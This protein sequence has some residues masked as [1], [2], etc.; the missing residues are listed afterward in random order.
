[1][2]TP[3]CDRIG[4]GSED[5][6]SKELDEHI[7]AACEMIKNEYG[8][9]EASNQAIF[10]MKQTIKTNDITA[11]RA[12]F[13]YSMF[14][15]EPVALYFKKHEQSSRLAQDLRQRVLPFIV[16]LF[17]KNSCQSPDG[18]V[19]LSMVLA[20]MWQGETLGNFPPPEKSV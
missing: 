5:H 19:L 8:D 18:F 4:E 13:L 7:I 20:E 3:L 14:A 16:P 11:K 6:V 15:D 9:C 17:I 1:M 2:G 12:L 10:E